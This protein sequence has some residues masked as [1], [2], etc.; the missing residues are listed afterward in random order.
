MVKRIIS[1]SYIDTDASGSG[2]LHYMSAGTPAYTISKAAL[3]LVLNFLEFNDTNL[4]SICKPLSFNAL[5][6]FKKLGM[7]HCPY[8]TQREVAMK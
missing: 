4:Y 2:S 8:Y 5:C 6:S 3:I 1:Y 7:S